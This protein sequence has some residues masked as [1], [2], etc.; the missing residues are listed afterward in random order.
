MT[1]DEFLLNDINSRAFNENNFYFWLKSV[2]DSLNLLGSETDSNLERIIRLLL[3]YYTGAD[4][5]SEA[6]DSIPSEI[7]ALRGKSSWM[8][9]SQL[10]I[11]YRCISDIAASR[12]R[13]LADLYDWQYGVVSA[14]GLINFHDNKDQD[15]IALILA[16]ASRYSVNLYE[17]KDE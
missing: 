8:D 2:I 5:T 12:E 9:N 4:I 10:G 11:K 1:I 17:V 7:L 3:D 16:N 13:N 14:F 6:I 15:L